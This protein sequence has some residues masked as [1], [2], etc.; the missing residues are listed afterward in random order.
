MGYL[1][2]NPECRMV[3]GPR[4]V[5]L[6]D[7]L[8]GDMHALEGLESEFLVRAQGPDPVE[9]LL[10]GRGSE[11]QGRLRQFLRQLAEAG[12]A[13]EYDSPYYQKVFER[14]L[15]GGF[16]A[17]FQPT[18]VHMFFCEVTQSCD[19]DCL[20]CR[21]SDIAGRGTGCG[22]HND[23]QG[24]PLTT[25]RRKE[26]IAQAVDLGVID[27]HLCGGDVMAAPGWDDLV[28]EALALGVPQVTVWTS[29][30]RPI[31]D[32][33][34]QNPRVRFALQVFSHLEQVHDEVAGRS[35]A[36]AALLANLERLRQRQADPVLTLVVTRHN[37]EGYE[38]TQAFFQAY[39]RIPLRIA[40]LYPTGRPGLCPTRSGTALLT[41]KRWFV[42][43]DAGYL[44]H[45]EGFH[46]CWNGKLA[47]TT[48]GRVLPCPAGRPWVMGDAR[49]EDLWS[50]L[51][52]G[53][54]KPYWELSK[55]R[56]PK[57]S[58]CEFRLGC[59]DCRVIQGRGKS[60]TEVAFCDYDPET[61]LWE[62]E[63][64]SPGEMGDGR[65]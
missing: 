51:S 29:G 42:R 15:G 43:A 1:R 30:F 11:E 38:E 28:S 58:R 62:R 24:P 27:L 20:F 53:R 7:T 25:E 46:P 4:N 22:R 56:L 39:S 59:F 6:Y 34:L 16:S 57:C 41:A 50:I 54:H 21:G 63:R 52:A 18:R 55:A 3:K 36:L 48:D 2:L 23:A 37:E 32:P 64:P 44:T 47:V 49:V 8:R 10:A 19:L 33:W 65:S 31:E 14:G 13:V 35:G 61:G 9:A 12:L 26:L 5:C 45:F 40:A 17:F 60:L